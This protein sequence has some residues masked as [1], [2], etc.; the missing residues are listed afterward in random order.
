MTIITHRNPTTVPLS[1]S[2]PSGEAAANVLTRSTAPPTHAQR[3]IEQ[4]SLPRGEAR[5]QHELAALRYDYT[6]IDEAHRQAVQEAALAIQ[7]RERRAAQDLIAI[8]QHLIE[9]KRRLEH[10]DFTD[11]LD[12]EFG[13]SDRTARSFMSVAREYG[14]KTEIASVLSGTMLVL[15]SAPSTPTE[16][17]AAIEAEIAATGHTPTRAQVKRAIDAYKPPKPHPKSV[18]KLTSVVVEPE[19]QPA[20]IEA[21]Y[22]VAPAPSETVAEI[23][24]EGNHPG[25]IPKETETVAEPQPATIEAEYRLIRSEQDLV[26][27][28]LDRTLAHKL[29]AAVLIRALRYQMTWD[30]QEQIIAALGRALE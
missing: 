18:E 24:R 30:E 13:Y 16:A 26:T 25:S 22:I 8:G 4:R 21:E 6:T 9:V 17:R 28:T 1:P 23:L 3:M 10:G 2:S 29:H 11:W 12:V 15:L 7:G 14:G 20:T 5:G 19:P 27:L